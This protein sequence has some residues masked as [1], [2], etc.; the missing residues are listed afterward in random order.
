M[1]KILEKKVWLSEDPAI[2]EFVLALAIGVFIGTYSS[3]FLASPLLAV[4]EKIKK[5][6]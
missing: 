5:Q 4:W 2:K 6:D 1:Y 3:I